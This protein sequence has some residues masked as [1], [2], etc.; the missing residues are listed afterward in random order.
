[1]NVDYAFA[2]HQH[3]RGASSAVTGGGCKPH[4]GGA[5]PRGSHYLVTPPYKHPVLH[6]GLE[7][8]VAMPSKRKS[9]EDRPEALSLSRLHARSGHDGLPLPPPAVAGPSASPML[10][11]RIGH[12]ATSTRRTSPSR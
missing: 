2:L 1:M 5:S 10:A 7:E 6:A 8:L 12:R 11:P 3:V 4:V 9:L